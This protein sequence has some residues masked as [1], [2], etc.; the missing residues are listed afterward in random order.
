[1]ENPSHG[2]IEGTAILIAVFLVVTV[3]AL[4][5]RSHEQSQLI[6]RPLNLTG[7]LGLSKRETVQE[8]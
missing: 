2:W 5:V 4:N 6:N 3:T 1:M 7:S 8:T